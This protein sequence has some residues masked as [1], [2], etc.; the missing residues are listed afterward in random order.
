MNQEESATR[1]RLFPPLFSQSQRAVYHLMLFREGSYYLA[2]GALA[3]QILVCEKG[4][5][6]PPRS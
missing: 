2:V 4:T 3:A 1:L 5:W 6:K